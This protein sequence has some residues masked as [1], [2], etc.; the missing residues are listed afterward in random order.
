[1]VLVPF[2]LCPVPCSLVISLARTKPALFV[3]ACRALSAT[4]RTLSSIFE[5]VDQTYVMDAGRPL[6]AQPQMSGDSTGAGADVAPYD[7]PRAHVYKR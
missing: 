2:L 4:D 5:A 6:L 3:D 1:M 7:A